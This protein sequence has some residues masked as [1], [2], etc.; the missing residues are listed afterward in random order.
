MNTT[1][2]LLLLLALT[3]PAHAQSL[4][5]LAR[6]VAAERAATHQDGPAPGKRA[7]TNAD[8]YVPVEPG[9]QDT[10]APTPDNVLVCQARSAKALIHAMA[11]EHQYFLPT[12]ATLAL[13]SKPALAAAEKAD[14]AG[15]EKGFY[16]GAMV[17]ALKADA[18]EATRA[19][20][21]ARRAK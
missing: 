1:I 14:N 16:P 15:C 8:L 17:A 6:Q 18:A 11:Q 20:D 3:S 9:N 19:L 4:G 21:A 12:F 5:E 10:F 13:K 2:R 7:F